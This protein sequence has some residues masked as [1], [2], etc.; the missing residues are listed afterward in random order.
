MQEANTGGVIEY[1]TQPA[2]FSGVHSLWLHLAG[3]FGGD[4]LEVHF[5]GL[6]GEFTE[7]RRQAVAAT[8]EA[9]PLPADHPVPGG[10]LGAR[11]GM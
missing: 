5:I 2:R 4:C 6:K 11:L 7:R 8:Y 3:N 1:P 9:R 10:P